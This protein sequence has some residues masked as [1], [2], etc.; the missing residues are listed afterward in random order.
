MCYIAIVLWPVVAFGPY[1]LTHWGWATH[2]C[3]DNLTII[4]SDNGL[5]LDRRQAIIETNAGI[6]LIR[7]LGTNLN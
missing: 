1:P 3:V 4:G 6:L 5:S 2:T 7:P